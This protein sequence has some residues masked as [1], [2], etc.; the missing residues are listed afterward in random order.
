MSTPV[1]HLLAASLPK[2]TIDALLG[3]R[4]RIMFNV[5]ST[6][7]GH[8]DAA[9]RAASKASS[10]TGG[11]AAS[12]RTEDDLVSS[13]GNNT[14]RSAGCPGWEICVLSVGVASG[15]ALCGN[16]GA[17]ELMSFNVLS[18]LCGWS[19]A[20]ERLA[21]QGLGSCLA[22]SSIA[23]LATSV[24]L[25]GIPLLLKHHKHKP[26][27]SLRIWAIQCICEQKEADQGEWMYQRQ[28]AI[29]S[30]PHNGFNEATDAYLK[31]EWGKARDNLGLWIL[32][33]SGVVPGFAEELQSLISAALE[34]DTTSPTAV[35]L[36]DAAHIARPRDPELAM[37][38]TAGSQAGLGNSRGPKIS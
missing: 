28:N 35:L 27:S 31:G 22:D 18:T 37:K 2:G 25:R 20:L 15:S 21:A 12:V 36:H 6:C 9:A 10:P 11:E 26:E 14:T 1:E 7:S 19:Y 16:V 38:G 8:R 30:N 13:G 24:M 4:C 5:S 29:A 3:D 17:E 32:S 33:R 23:E 34:E